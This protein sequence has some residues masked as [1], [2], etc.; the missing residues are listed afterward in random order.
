MITFKA[1]L[2]SLAEAT[3]DK[4]FDD[5]MKGIEDKGRK[6][7]EFGSKL[8][9][10]ADSL[11]AEI[12]RQKKLESWV[13]DE[14]KKIEAIPNKMLAPFAKAL[15]P[16]TDGYQK[17]TSLLDVL[18]FSARNKD[19]HGYSHDA[20]EPDL[21]DIADNFLATHKEEVRDVITS[22]D[23]AYKKLKAAASAEKWPT[24]NDSWMHNDVT[25]FAS[26]YHMFKNTV[27]YLKHH[28]KD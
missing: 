21:A 5:M 10:M 3:G 1:F 24:G 14:L 9:D 25:K 23:A 11:P 15:K 26:H 16:L 12:D 22:V 7:A 8:K 28:L 2:K 13:R 18:M 6:S 19:P 17:G 4:K 20:D 27:E